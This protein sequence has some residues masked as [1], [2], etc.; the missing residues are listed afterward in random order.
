MAAELV[1]TSRLWGRVAVGKHLD[2]A[3]IQLVK[4]TEGRL[5][6]YASYTLSDVSI[7]SFTTNGQDSEAP[8]D[9]ITRMDVSRA[10]SEQVGRTCLA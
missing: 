8:Q 9:S 4:A 7:T 1:E 2:S 6:V 5:Q 3:T 10:A